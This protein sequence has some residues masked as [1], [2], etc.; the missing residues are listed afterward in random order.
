MKASGASRQLLEIVFQ[1]LRDAVFI[2]DADMIEIIDCNPAAERIFGYG[3]EE[4][5]RH[6]IAFL[7]VDEGALETFRAHLYPSMKEQGFLYLPEFK[8]KRKNGDIFIGEHSVI[9][10]KDNSGQQVGWLSVVR[11]I[12]ERVRAERT[13]LESEIWLDT[14]LRSISDAVIANDAEGLV[15]FMN[16]I[17]ESLTGWDEA[18]AKGRSLE[19]VFNITK[20]QTEEHAEGTVIKAPWEGVAADLTSHTVLMAKDGTERPIVDSW[21]PMKDVMGNTIGTVIV[22]QDITERKRVEEA[23]R[24]SQQLKTEF[25]QNVSHELRTPLAIA[26]GYAELLEDGTLGQLL[27]KQQEPISIIVRRLRMLSELVS[28]ITAILEAETRDLQQEPVDLTDL[29]LKA[30]DHF[31]VIAR[32]Q[33]L[34]LTTKVAPDLPPVLGDAMCLYRVLDNLLGNALKFTP[35]GGCITVCL[36]QSRESLVLEVADTGIGIPPDR[37]ERIFE[38]FYQVN[39]SSRRRYGGVGLGLALVKE[40]VETHDGEISVESEVGRGSI[41]TVTLPIYGD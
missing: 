13:L 3:R 10:L 17:A 41:F 24:Q 6:P 29:V 27:P 2:I 38:R 18:D 1:S 12:T 21:A 14:T 35:V 34:I 9:P 25:I 32:Q 16:P 19:D 39:G 4:M 8:M 28:D 37:Q 15:T 33:G 26:R 11:D 30:V 20:E 5:L 31:Q 23:L 7:H 40:I 22:F 36:R